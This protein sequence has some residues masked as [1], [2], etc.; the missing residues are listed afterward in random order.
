MIKAK[1][2]ANIGNDSGKVPGN[3]PTSIRCK[4]GINNE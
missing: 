4:K 3:I 2:Q 1:T